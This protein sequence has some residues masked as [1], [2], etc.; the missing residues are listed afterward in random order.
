MSLEDE[1]DDDDE[2]DCINTNGND[3]AITAVQAD[4]A[5]L[6]L[7]DYATQEGHSTAHIEL[8]RK[9][10]N[11]IHTERHK[12]HSKVQT[13]LHQFFSA[14]TKGSEVHEI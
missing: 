9:V 13:S 10:Q 1:G 7:L 3:S 14:R 4:N 8:L 5:V 2:D 12:N 11:N 6:M